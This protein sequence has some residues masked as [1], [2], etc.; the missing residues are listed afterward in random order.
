MWFA[1]WEDGS[2]LEA[3]SWRLASELALRHPDTTRLIRAHPGG[4]LSDCL[5]FLPT[6]GAK[7]D[8]RLNRNG[9]IQVLERFDGRVPGWPPT[10]WDAYFRA[11]PRRFLREL[12][13]AAGLPAPSTTPP[14]T[15]RTLTLRVLAALAGMG[16]KSIEPVEIVPGMI[17]TSG[18]GG[19]VNDEAFEAFPAIPREARVPQDDDLFGHGEYRFWFVRRGDEYVLAL[20]QGAALAWTRHHQNTWSLLD[21]Y[22]E[23]RRHL[24]VTALKLLRRVDQI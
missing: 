18:D 11:D 17:D 24:L 7:G 5:W 3:A 20:E 12:E 22:V 13:A 19:G 6:T 2:L 10:E 21:V 1:G 14:S 9:R 8:F 23:S 16:L 15:P 4:G